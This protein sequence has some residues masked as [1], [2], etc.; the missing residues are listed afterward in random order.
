MGRGLIRFVWW[1]LRGR[2]E[3]L[4]ILWVGFVCII[5]CASLLGGLTDLSTLTT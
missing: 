3:H 5:I 1:S 2:W 4:V